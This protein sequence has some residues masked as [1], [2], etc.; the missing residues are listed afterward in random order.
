MALDAEWIEELF[1]GLGPVRLRRMF[2]GYGVYAGDYCVGLALG[3]GICLRCDAA[4]EARYRAIGARPFTYTAR[5]KTVTVGA[6]WLLPESL[7][8]EPDALTDWARLS[9]D[10]ARA[11][12]PKKKRSAAPKPRRAKTSK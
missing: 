4:S 7:L 2:S 1:A 10:I 11:L 6:W 9:L 3:D 12:P 5:G 8:D